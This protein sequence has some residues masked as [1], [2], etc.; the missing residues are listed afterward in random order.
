MAAPPGSPPVL[1]ASANGGR[2]SAGAVAQLAAQDLAG[3]RLRDLVDHLDLP[4]VLVGGHPL[5]AERDELLL[6]GRGAV[7]QADERLHRLAPVL[8]RDAD[9]GRLADRR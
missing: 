4:R 5:P 9:D 1:E 3:R 2:E 8:V 7:L 6:A